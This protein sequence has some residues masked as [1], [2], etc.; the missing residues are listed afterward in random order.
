MKNRILVVGHDEQLPVVRLIL[1]NNHWEGTHLDPHQA[2]RQLQ[3]E[4]PDL[5]VLSETLSSDETQK[6]IALCRF[7]LPQLPLLALEP[8]T[9]ST[10]ALRVDARVGCTPASFVHLLSTIE[11]LLTE[12]ASA[13]RLIS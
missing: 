10:H 8:R 13:G 3:I 2:L 12:S 11:L 4:A 6:L 9:G 1:L 7:Q 5:L